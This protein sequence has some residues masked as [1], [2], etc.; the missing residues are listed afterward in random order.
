MEL[1]EAVCLIDFHQLGFQFSSLDLSRKLS[2]SEMTSSESR[3]LYVSSIVIKHSR[4]LFLTLLN[5]ICFGHHLGFSRFRPKR[6]RYSSKRIRNT[7]I[8]QLI[9]YRTHR[10]IAVLSTSPCTEVLRH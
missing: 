5:E 6:V 2:S 4:V 3:V 7:I 9:H 1:K 8:R 10:S